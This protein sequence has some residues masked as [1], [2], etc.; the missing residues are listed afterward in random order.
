MNQ[1]QEMMFWKEVEYQ[2]FLNRIKPEILY[3]HDCGYD[4]YEEEQVFGLPMC[5]KIS[6]T[7]NTNR[8][9]K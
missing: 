2:Q 7:T 3:G 6:K 8:K 1:L 9:I 5:W 4:G